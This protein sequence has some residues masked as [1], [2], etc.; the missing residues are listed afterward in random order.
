MS[1]AK[2]NAVDENPD[3]AE[4]KL[5]D[6]LTQWR[7]ERPDIDPAAMAVCGEVWRAGEV[8]RKGVMANVARYDLDFPQF[9]VILTLRRQGRGETL[10][11][12]VLAKEMMLSTSAMTN[13]LDRLEKRGLIERIADPNDRRALKIA[14]TEAGYQLSDE[15][16][17]SHVETEDGLLDGLERAEWEQLRRLLG[18]I[19]LK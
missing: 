10:S 4:K 13:R 2:K 7:C 6:I 19:Q 12:S 1:Q 9:D 15:M 11:P 8:L 17:V 3:I 5:D 18:K 14:L 16:V